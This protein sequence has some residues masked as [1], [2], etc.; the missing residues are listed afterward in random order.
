[1]SDAMRAIDLGA[2]AWSR[3]RPPKILKRAGLWELG[4]PPPPEADPPPPAT[5]APAEPPAP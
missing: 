4:P 1:M 2:A 5:A 3:E